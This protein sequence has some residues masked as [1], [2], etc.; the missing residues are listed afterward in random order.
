MSS[1]YFSC[2]RPYQLNQSLGL[3]VEPSPPGFSFLNGQ[4]VRNCPTGMTMNDLGVCIRPVMTRKSFISDA[5]IQQTTLAIGGNSA[6]GG[7][8]AVVFGIYDKSAYDVTFQLAQLLNEPISQV[9]LSPGS[10]SLFLVGQTSASSPSASLAA[11]QE[12]LSLKSVT[13]NSIETPTATINSQD[14]LPS[15]VRKMEYSTAGVSGQ[16]YFLGQPATKIFLADYPASLY[17]TAKNVNF[18]F[19]SEVFSVEGTTDPFYAGSIPILI[20]D[21]SGNV[22]GSQIGAFQ[23]GSSNANPKPNLSPPSAL[24]NDSAGPQIQCPNDTFWPQTPL[25]PL[26]AI[27]TEVTDATSRNFQR[28][29]QSTSYGYVLVGSQNGSPTAYAARYL[30]TGNGSDYDNCPLQ[31]PPKRPFVQTLQNVDLSAFQ[32][33]E[34]PDI[35]VARFDVDSD[36]NGNA[37]SIYVYGMCTKQTSPMNVLMFNSENHNYNTSGFFGFSFGSGLAPP[38]S[39]FTSFNSQNSNGTTTIIGQFI[40]TADSET[41]CKAFVNQLNEVLLNAY[42]GTAA[43]LQFNQSNWTTLSTLTID[44]V[45][46]PES[47]FYASLYFASNSF[48]D[49]TSTRELLGFQNNNAWYTMNTQ[50]TSVTCSERPVP[51]ASENLNAY[52]G[53]STTDTSTRSNGSAMTELSPVG[54]KGPNNEMV[55]Q[56][57]DAWCFDNFSQSL[58]FSVAS[59]TSSSGGGLNGSQQSGQF[60]RSTYKFDVDSPSFDIEVPLNCIDIEVHL[61]GAGGSTSGQG[62][63]GSGAYVSG[64]LDM[65]KLGLKALETLKVVVGSG[66]SASASASILYGSGGQ[67]NYGPLCKGGGRSAIQRHNRDIV[68]A[69]GGGGSSGSSM[70]FGGAASATELPA[71]S[72]LPDANGGRGAS[73]TSAGLGGIVFGDARYKRAPDG[74]Q[75]RGGPSCSTL[76]KSALGAGG[77]GS[78]YYGGGSGAYLGNKSPNDVP[79]GSGGGSSYSSNLL[80]PTLISGSRDVAPQNTTFKFTDVAYGGTSAT[81]GLGAHGRVIVIFTTT[82]N[83]NVSSSQFGSGS[84]FTNQIW[85]CRPKAFSIMSEKSVWGTSTTNADWTSLFSQLSSPFS[86]PTLETR[87]I[88]TGLQGLIIFAQQDSETNESYISWTI[89]NSNK[90]TNGSVTQMLAVPDQLLGPLNYLSNDGLTQ[91]VVSPITN[92]RSIRQ[93]GTNSRDIVFIGDGVRILSAPSVL[94]GSWSNARFVIDNLTGLPINNFAL[95][96]AKYNE[97]DQVVEIIGAPATLAISTMHKTPW[98]PQFASFY[99]NADI[100]TEIVP[101][102]PWTLVLEPLSEVT[103]N[104]SFSINSVGPLVGPSGV[105]YVVPNA[106]VTTEVPNTLFCARLLN[107]ANDVLVD[108][109]SVTLFD[110]D[111]EDTTIS[112]IATKIESAL[113]AYMNYCA[114]KVVSLGQPI[115]SVFVAPF[116]ILDITIVDLDVNVHI[117]LAFSVEDSDGPWDWQNLFGGSNSIDTVG[118]ALGSAG[119]LMGFNAEI[120]SSVTQNSSQASPERFESSLQGSF[121]IELRPSNTSTAS[122]TLTPLSVA[123]PENSTFAGS[124]YHVYAPTVKLAVVDSSRPN[125]LWPVQGI[126]V[127]AGGPIASPVHTTV[128]NSL[129]NSFLDQPVPVPGSK[130]FIDY[131]QSQDLTWS[132]QYADGTIVPNVF[133]PLNSESISIACTD[134]RSPANLLYSLDSGASYNYTE[135]L[136]GSYLRSKSLPSASTFALNGLDAFHVYRGPNSGGFTNFAIGPAKMFSESKNS[137]SLN[138]AVA[139]FNDIKFIP[140]EASYNGTTVP[141][142]FIGVGQFLWE[143]NALA[144]CTWPTSINQLNGVAWVSLDGISWTTMPIV[145]ANNGNNIAGQGSV[146]S[147]MFWQCTRLDYV[148]TTNNNATLITD[149]GLYM[150]NVET[151]MSN[152]VSLFTHGPILNFAS[153]GPSQT[154]FAVPIGLN[155]PF[156]AH[157]TSRDATGTCIK[158]LRPSNGGPAAM[159]VSLPQIIGPGGAIQPNFDCCIS[160]VRGDDSVNQVYTSVESAVDAY[161]LSAYAG[162]EAK[163]SKIKSYKQS[164]FAES[165]LGPS[166]DSLIICPRFTDY[167]ETPAGVIGVDGHVADQMQCALDNAMQKTSLTLYANVNGIAVVRLPGTV[168]A[169]DTSYGPASQYIESY[170][171]ETRWVTLV[172]YDSKV[173]SVTKTRLV[174]PD[175]C[176]STLGLGG[177]A[178]E[179]PLTLIGSADTYPVSLNSNSYKFNADSVDPVSGLR[180][181]LLSKITNQGAF[182]VIN[183]EAL[184]G[185]FLQN[186]S[187]ESSASA[188]WVPGLAPFDRAILAN[189]ELQ[190][191]F[192]YANQGTK[193][194]YN[195]DQ[196]GDSSKQTQNPYLYRLSSFEFPY[197]SSNGKLTLG[198]DPQVYE[199]GFGALKHYLGPNEP[200]FAR[201][202]FTDST[203]PWP[204]NPLPEE[205]FGYW[206]IR[207]NVSSVQRGV[208]TGAN[209]DGLFQSALGYGTIIFQQQLGFYGPG[210]AAK[211]GYSWPSVTSQP[212]KAETLFC[213]DTSLAS[214]ALINK[215]YLEQ[216]WTK[217]LP[218]QNLAP[219]IFTMDT[220]LNNSWT[221]LTLANSFRAQRAQFSL[222]NLLTLKLWS[223]PEPAP[224]N[225]TSTMR[226]T[227]QTSNNNN[228][229]FLVGLN[230]FRPRNWAF[231]GLLVDPETGSEIQ[232]EIGFGINQQI[233]TSDQPD[234]LGRYE[235]LVPDPYFAAWPNATGYG[236][237]SDL[238]G[239]RTLLQGPSAD[240][241]PTILKVLGVSSVPSCLAVIETPVGNSASYAQNHCAWH[242]WTFNST[243]STATLDLY[244]NV[245][246]LFGNFEWLRNCTLQNENY[247]YNLLERI[248]NS[249]GATTDFEKGLI[250]SLIKYNGNPILGGPLNSFV[251]TDPSSQTTRS[252]ASMNLQCESSAQQKMFVYASSEIIQT[253]NLLPSGLQKR[254]KNLLTVES[255]YDSTGFSLLHHKYTVP[256]GFF[257]TKVWPV[258]QVLGPMASQNSNA[259][260]LLGLD[261]ANS[262]GRKDTVLGPA[263]PRGLASSDNFIFRP[264]AS[265]LNIT[266]SDYNVETDNSGL[267]SS[268]QQ[269]K[270]VQDL[271]A[272]TFP[273]GDQYGSPTYG[274]GLRID[275]NAIKLENCSPNA[276]NNVRPS[277]SKSLNCDLPMDH[278][279]VSMVRT[280][281]DSFERYTDPN[282]SQVMSIDAWPHVTRL[283]YVTKYVPSKL[284]AYGAIV[285]Y[286]PMRFLA[287]GDATK[288]GSAQLQGLA[289]EETNLDLSV[290]QNVPNPFRP[291][292]AYLIE[293]VPIG[294][295]VVNGVH[296][297]AQW[298]RPNDIYGSVNGQFQNDLLW[299]SWSSNV[300]DFESPGF[301]GRQKLPFQN[302]VITQFFDATGMENVALAEIFNSSS[303]YLFAG[304]EGIWDNQ[305]LFLNGSN[306]I[307]PNCQSFRSAFNSTQEF[308]QATLNYSTNGSSN[309]MNWLKDNSKTIAGQMLVNLL[310]AINLDSNSTTDEIR[311]ELGFYTDSQNSNQFRGRI[312]C[313]EFFRKFI[314]NTGGAYFQVIG[315]NVL[316]QNER[317]LLVTHA[318]LATIFQI[319]M[320]AWLNDASDP[321][322][323][324]QTYAPSLTCIFDALTDR[325]TFQFQFL[326]GTCSKL[327]LYVPSPLSN[328]LGLVNMNSPMYNIAPDNGKT[329]LNYSA[330]YSNSIFDTYYYN[331]S[332]SN[333]IT[334]LNNY[335]ITEDANWNSNSAF[336]I[337]PWDWTRISGNMINSMDPQQPTCSSGN[338]TWLI[339]EGPAVIHNWN[340]DGFY[341]NMQMVQNCTS[342]TR[343]SA[344]L[345]KGPLQT[346]CNFGTFGSNN[347]NFVGNL[348]DLLLEGEI[349]NS[350]SRS[351][352]FANS[353][354]PCSANSWTTSGW[355]DAQNSPIY[356]LYWENTSGSNEIV[357][358]GRQ[359]LNDNNTFAMAQHG[360]GSGGYT[361]C[362]ISNVSWT[363]RLAASLDSAT[364]ANTKCA[365]WWGFVSA[366]QS[367]ASISTFTAYHADSSLITFNASTKMQTQ[368]SEPGPALFM[369]SLGTAQPLSSNST[370]QNLSA[371]TF[372]DAAW[373]PAI[374][375]PC[376]YGNVGLESVTK[377]L[378][379]P[380]NFDSIRSPSATESATESGCPSTDTVVGSTTLA[381]IALTN[382]QFATR[383]TFGALVP[384]KPTATSGT[385]EQP[386]QLSLSALSSTVPNNDQNV[387]RQSGPVRPTS[388]SSPGSTTTDANALA[389]FMVSDSCYVNVGPTAFNTG[390]QGQFTRLGLYA[391][392]Y[393]DLFAQNSQV[394]PWLTNATN[395]LRASVVDSSAYLKTYLQGTPYYMDE[396]YD[397]N[398]YST[399]GRSLFI[400]SSMLSSAT[401]MPLQVSSAQPVVLI[402]CPVSFSPQ[403]KFSRTSTRPIGT[404]LITNDLLNTYSNSLLYSFTEPY[405]QPQNSGMQNYGPQV[406]NLAFTDPLA[407]PAWTF[408]GL[409]N[410]KSVGQNGTLGVQASKFS[411][412]PDMQSL[413][414]KV[415]RTFTNADNETLGLDVRQVYAQTTSSLIVANDE[416]STDP[417]SGANGATKNWP[418]A[419]GLSNAYTFQYTTLENPDWNN[420]SQISSSYLPLAGLWTSDRD[421]GW[422]GDS[423]SGGQKVQGAFRQMIPNYDGLSLLAEWQDGLGDFNVVESS[424]LGPKLG[425]GFTLYAVDRTPSITN[426][427][428]SDAKS[429]SP[430]SIDMYNQRRPQT[431]FSLICD[432]WRNTIR[433]PKPLAGTNSWILNASGT[434]APALTNGDGSAFIVD[435]VDCMGP[436]DYNINDATNN[437]YF[438]MC[439]G[440]L[441]GSKSLPAISGPTTSA[442]WSSTPW[443]Q[444]N[445]NSASLQVWSPFT[446]GSFWNTFQGG[447]NLNDTASDSAVVNFSPNLWWPTYRW[448]LAATDPNNVLP[449]SVASNVTLQLNSFVLF[450]CTDGTI[451][452]MKMPASG[453]GSAGTSGAFPVVESTTITTFYN[454]DINAPNGNP[455]VYSY[456]A[457]GR[458]YN[459]TWFANHWWCTADNSS[460][461]TTAPCAD[462]TIIN[463]PGLVSGFYANVI[464]FRPLS[465]NEGHPENWLSAS[466]P[467]NAPHRYNVAKLIQFNNSEALFIGSVDGEYIVINQVGS[468]FQSTLPSTDYSV[469]WLFPNT[470]TNLDSSQSTM[471]YVTDIAILGQSLIVGSSVLPLDPQT[472]TSVP[473]TMLASGTTKNLPLPLLALSYS[474][475]SS[476]GPTLIMNGIHNIWPGT[477]EDANVITTLSS[478]SIQNTVDL[479]DL[480]NGLEQVVKQV[481]I[482]T[483][484][485]QGSYDTYGPMGYS[486][487]DHTNSNNRNFSGLLRF[488]RPSNLGLNNNDT[489]VIF[490]TETETDTLNTK[491]ST[492]TIGSFYGIVNSQSQSN[493]GSTLISLQHSTDFINVES[494]WPQAS[495]SPA[496]LTSAKINTFHKGGFSMDRYTRAFFVIDSSNDTGSGSSSGSSGGS[497]GGESANYGLGLKPFIIANS[498]ATQNYQGTVNDNTT[499]KWNASYV[500]TFS[501][502]EGTG[503]SPMWN[504]SVAM[505]FSSGFYDG[506]V[507]D[508][509]Y[510]AAYTSSLK[511]PQN[512]PLDEFSN[513]IQNFNDLNVYQTMNIKRAASVPANVYISDMAFA[514]NAQAVAFTTAGPFG[515]LGPTVAQIVRSSDSTQWVPLSL[516]PSR[517]NIEPRFTGSSIIAWNPYELKW[518]AAG[519]ATNMPDVDFNNTDLLRPTGIDADS[520]SSSIW[521]PSDKQLNANNTRLM[522]ISADASLGPFTM[523]AENV[524]ESI[525]FTQ[526]F[527]VVSRNSSDD[528]AILKPVSRNFSSVACIAFSPNAVVIGGMQSDA[529]TGALTTA[530]DQACLMWRT[531]TIPSGDD[532]RA[533]WSFVNLKANGTVSAIKFVGYA[534]YI[535]TWDKNANVDANGVPQGQSSLFFASI[536]FTV[537]SLLDTWSGLNA[538]LNINSIE[539]T[540]LA[541][542]KC[543]ASDG[544]EVDP[545]NPNGCVKICPVGYK[546][547]GNLCVLNCPRPYIETGVP[548]ECQ[549]DVQMARTINPTIGGINPDLDL[550][551][552]IKNLS[553]GQENTS[554]NY[555]SLPMLIFIGLVFVLLLMSFIKIN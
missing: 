80:R 61:W 338:P 284:Q 115:V 395:S 409:D 311:I 154:I 402:L 466:W 226:R 120:V 40:P 345:D 478:P 413:P 297:S 550:T 259:V 503:P 281:V 475:A 482:D 468:G 307:G 108:F 329:N 234:A 46:P 286:Q 203:S 87:T 481:Q 174:V 227:T 529:T 509:T 67:G 547:Y 55:G 492:T 200:G 301:W 320:T 361:L 464:K 247:T 240:D 265:V 169:R 448:A 300:F 136:L 472:Q 189:D 487:Y 501:S 47:N 535:A 35:R 303:N 63:G 497:S 456:T 454:N 542:T 10:E 460:V 439:N 520:W 288:S 273:D 271:M 537:V 119:R 181:S 433:E 52:N 157:C 126:V 159:P 549:P 177:S 483:I 198:R 187:L 326:G 494:T 145:T 15:S 528:A 554:V 543:S 72:G 394:Q 103:N 507:P 176:P 116:N 289:I 467:S 429:T 79:T 212:T 188:N 419:L 121:S 512:G 459:L 476:Q 417:F 399:L 275:E 302:A 217:Y 220:A 109:V 272:Q 153:P 372:L 166:N 317:P 412:G 292:S 553:Q 461:W 263:D 538:T 76:F 349:S 58:A 6:E 445:S 34:K 499:N 415:Y 403:G 268:P 427:V 290:I 353:P 511:I 221:S 358:N 510:A 16:M 352:T 236:P 357:F 321:T 531:N 539:S 104:N 225:L 185:P 23:S 546:A 216:N 502:A 330:K 261:T 333:F 111:S 262:A 96:D 471:L 313:Q 266:T 555:G 73:S 172:P 354:L 204:A 9:K 377:N 180:L 296:V 341:I 344:W 366:S 190:S 43:P 548:N 251:W 127:A 171:K 94:N 84:S 425:P 322:F 385:L 13:Q 374:E 258:G 193:L 381:Q 469:P 191:D 24:G 404:N 356:S 332:K 5:S 391:F 92:I 392:N 117:D 430:I 513:I 44:L 397:G 179:A 175:T 388:T 438:G 246:K 107:S 298:I 384:L 405:A 215:K 45:L 269:Q 122:S 91:F 490:F 143:L 183:D 214:P 29:I 474:P 125:N 336:Y 516:S 253:V 218:F 241:L 365:H 4:F 164:F 551:S 421:A 12:F 196:P 30:Q 480:Q 205:G 22:A 328:W 362:D 56:N 360:E 309:Y 423:V 545:N 123:L 340:Y 32:S 137:G 440:T 316:A 132:W 451:R 66:G 170:A 452:K 105:A 485:K 393:T 186:K 291:R 500:R 60:L 93:I 351:V 243:N 244:V 401:G 368:S 312:N 533:N 373:I 160:A 140:Y 488:V 422:I 207:P 260:N 489:S 442:S 323:N 470:N 206:W 518:Y 463:D 465:A 232:Q 182:A 135:S 69:G 31:D 491:V 521:D 264:S 498:N 245:T 285:P 28:D 396:S 363:T 219:S 386:F 389:V 525:G 540:T 133:E 158:C 150:I 11:Q 408:Y 130:Y 238:I 201:S 508:D 239:I 95:N 100:A 426:P 530:N 21:D 165:A 19:R 431:V 414:R 64:H 86:R 416:P 325:P 141:G 279:Y 280:C 443:S 447:S 369:S 57:I 410:I 230:F 457:P 359:G 295:L 131:V 48:I 350:I 3:C 224:V 90:P 74:G 8:N 161:G 26:P 88:F 257:G 343:I 314:V 156:A 383:Q 339:G 199:P 449:T 250:A 85:A 149:I 473:W 256:V 504:R 202:S 248:L 168:S 453:P 434:S 506:Q 112:S 524:L 308:V 146:G 458:L 335:G 129:A 68:T 118:L 99:D 254:Q 223:K 14:T 514:E 102:V 318:E 114:T 167:N 541:T 526:V 75:F 20:F 235:F 139:Q 304:Y 51:S 411:L 515:P 315:L 41:Y 294:P 50:Q 124:Q 534:W 142:F 53:F 278:G 517:Y 331:Y 387:W 78:G 406:Y 7:T 522:I 148:D 552:P 420:P 101:F 324:I 364:Y 151:L 178:I 287:S 38:A 110:H 310:D 231:R 70:S 450:T 486:L 97:K 496:G 437:G 255:D 89:L 523:N 342:P 375:V 210:S 42:P 299:S 39:A 147:E 319:A 477:L 378:T 155:G 355:T 194:V 400:D 274:F 462:G 283:T 209:P 222:Q 435:F 276:T 424:A 62:R 376:P 532:L 54:V 128:N 59:D 495:T 527:Q 138:A 27:F 382:W 1:A 134:I 327:R 173:N 270:I 71:E 418:L 163:N 36:T 192:S 249:L 77:G 37:D 305:P 162:Y 18:N 49:M 519:S 346:W 484:G 441:G 33:S 197:D 81:R 277:V 252:L 536:N 208:I 398:A 229:K 195:A 65:S 25:D 293:N 228:W 505:T 371:C 211:Q 184:D 370:S 233:L 2:P 144:C 113:Q 334:Y 17:T 493:L 267:F 348:Y 432:Q 455:R 380:A 213:Y 82:E 337:S 367:L 544:F 390:S 98:V 379:K 407:G 152:I 444:Q 242:Y 479:L 237:R 347:L 306:S 106:Y 83:E 428:Q 282:Q 446:G 436:S